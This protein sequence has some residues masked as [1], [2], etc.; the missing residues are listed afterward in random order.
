MSR[1]HVSGNLVTRGVP[2]QTVVDLRRRRHVGIS[3]LHACGLVYVAPD[4]ETILPTQLALS[5]T[6]II[7]CDGFQPR[8]KPEVG[9]LGGIVSWTMYTDQP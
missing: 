7:V 2:G 8:L 6:V 3:Q 5:G 9:R 1:C 4:V